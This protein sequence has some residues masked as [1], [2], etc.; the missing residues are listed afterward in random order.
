MHAVMHKFDIW[1]LADETEP[2]IIPDYHYLQ[3]DQPPKVL[4]PPFESSAPESLTEATRGIQWPEIPGITG[5][6]WL[7]YNAA[8][9]NL[10]PC[11][12]QIFPDGVIYDVYNSV[13][14]RALGL[15][16]A[17]GLARAVVVL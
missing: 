13:E 7:E 1:L 9:K 15:G 12:D 5:R 10:E 3:F 8:E 16:L 14:S 2:W 17:A 6:T 11:V 4:V